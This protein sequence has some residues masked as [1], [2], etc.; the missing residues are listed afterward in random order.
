MFEFFKNLFSGKAVLEVSLNPG[1][2]PEVVVS[3]PDLEAS[4]K[5]IRWVRKDNVHEFDFER[6]NDLNQAYFNKQSI[7][8]DRQKISCNN[9]APD[10]DEKFEYEIVVLWNGNP[11]DSTKSGSPPD[12]KPVIRNK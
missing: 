7:G 2:D 11:Y 9:R 10:T 6:L 12:G 1:G 4:G 3:E 8:L 5:K